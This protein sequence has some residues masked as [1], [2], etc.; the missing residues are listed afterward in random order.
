MSA[1]GFP[2][3]FPLKVNVPRGP[4]PLPKSIEVPILAAEFQSVRSLD[5]SDRGIN[6][7][8]VLGAGLR[9]AGDVPPK[10]EYTLFRL[11]A[12]KFQLD[13]PSSQP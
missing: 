8:R 12:G 4:W 7:G 3:H 2:V 5:P 6:G 1:K 13:L 9:L 11:M 10:L